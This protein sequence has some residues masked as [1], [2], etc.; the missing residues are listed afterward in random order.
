MDLNQEMQN[1][2]KNM[3]IEKHIENF[4]TLFRETRQDRKLEDYLVNNRYLASKMIQ[5][6]ITIGKI[7]TGGQV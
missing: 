4:T 5:E 2:I 6:Y 3:I 1:K 7:N